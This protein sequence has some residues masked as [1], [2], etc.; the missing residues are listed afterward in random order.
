[1]GKTN[2]VRV[3]L[4]VAKSQFFCGLDEFRQVFSYCG[5]SAAE[6]QRSSRYWAVQAQVF[7]HATDLLLGRFVNVSCCG[8]VGEADRTAEVAAVRD[9]YYRKPC[10]AFVLWADAAVHWA[11][12]VSLCARVVQPSSFFSV[13]FGALV[14]L[15]VAPVELIV[16]AVF[17]TGFFDVNFV[18]L[19]VY[20]G[21]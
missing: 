6:L 21:I 8:G 4:Y 2:A 9:V 17:R 16:L 14:L 12:L 13:F 7:E 3:D 10:V 18:V 19:L 20:C 11:L 15:I 1:L 5:F